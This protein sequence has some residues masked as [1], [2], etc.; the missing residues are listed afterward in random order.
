M[1]SDTAP[2]ASGDGHD[3]QA[4]VV[5]INNPSQPVTDNN[6]K[7]QSTQNH[8][9]HPRAR[10]RPFVYLVGVVAA[11]GGLLFGYD[12]GGSGGTFVMQ[13][14]REHFGW[15]WPIPKEESSAVLAQQGWINALFTL[16]ALV[17]A[18]PAG[19]LADRF[20]RRATITWAALLFTIAAS[21]QTASVNM[22]M[23]YTGR[24]FGGIAIGASELA[25]F[26]LSSA[27]DSLLSLS[28]HFHLETLS[29]FHISLWA[30][31]MLT[32]SWKMVFRCNRY[33][34]RYCARLHQRVCARALPWAVVD[35]VAARRNCGHRS[36]RGAQY[37]ASHLGGGLAHLLRW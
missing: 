31:P 11:M 17:G 25:C 15:A 21:V 12:I 30:V 20:G 6:E 8:K 5:P 13:G 16:G 1:T 36:C 7:I 23:M 18:V 2:R 22:D 4:S 29:R 9:P 27:V 32:C 19:T 28:S 3:V 34:L 24:F 33:R 10:V 14:F 35:S 37:P 26:V